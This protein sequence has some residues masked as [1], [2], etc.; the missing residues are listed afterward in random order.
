LKKKIK[1][2]FLIKTKVI[3]TLFLIINAL[4]LH[5]VDDDDGDKD[6]KDDNMELVI[7]FVKY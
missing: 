3:F 5:V 1:I 4:S 7:I 6:D 2:N